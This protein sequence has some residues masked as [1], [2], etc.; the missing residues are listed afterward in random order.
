MQLNCNLLLAIVSIVFFQ[1]EAKAPAAF[2]LSCV[3]TD[4]VTALRFCN[5]VTNVPLVVRH[6]AC[7]IIKHWIMKQQHIITWLITS[8][9]VFS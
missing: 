5:D 1:W 6:E 4:D 7:N 3:A 2:S 9:C 8:Y